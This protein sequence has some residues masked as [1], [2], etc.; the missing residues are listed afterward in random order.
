MVITLKWCMLC[1]HVYEDLTNMEQVR[2]T[3]Q[4]SIALLKESS[5]KFTNHKNRIVNV[6]VSGGP[7]VTTFQQVR[8]TH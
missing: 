5:H 7:A 3:V 6:L 4:Q 8:S 2:P 1:K